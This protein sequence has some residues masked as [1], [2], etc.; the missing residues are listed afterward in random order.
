MLVDLDCGD[1]ADLNFFMVKDGIDICPLH[2]AASKGSIKVL[3]IIL[4]N[5]FLNINLR[6]QAGLNAFWIACSYRNGEAMRMLA[7]KGIDMMVKSDEDVNPLHLA[8][9]KNYPE[10]VEMMLESGY[11]LDHE[12]KQGMTA[13]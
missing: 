6:N 4:E 13:F 3:E 8:V 10:L 2:A 12:T 1:E 9:K 11:P 7:N 5:K